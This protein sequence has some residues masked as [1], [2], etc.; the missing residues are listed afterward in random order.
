MAENIEPVVGEDGWDGWEGTEGAG[1]VE[2]SE[3]E[4]HGEDGWD[5]AEGVDGSEEAEVEAHA[6]NVLD[7]QAMKMLHEASD[8][9]C[10]SLISYVHGAETSA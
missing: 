3:V 1:W 4:A 2:G 6:A 10:F 7:L 5:G 8:G 9:A